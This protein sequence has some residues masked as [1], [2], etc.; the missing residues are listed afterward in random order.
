MNHFGMPKL[1]I[2]S[3]IEK[4]L[5]IEPCSQSFCVEK[6]EDRSKLSK[7]RIC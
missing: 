5:K 1:W 7:Q 3:I 2:E 4:L 6:E